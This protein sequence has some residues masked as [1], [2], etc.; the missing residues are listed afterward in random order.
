MIFIKLAIR[1]GELMLERRKNK[2]KEAQFTK[3]II[4]ENDDGT[5]RYL[6]GDVVQ[7]WEDIMN[8]LVTLGFVHG[9]QGQAGLKSIE[10]KTAQSLRELEE[11]AP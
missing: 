9:E 1:I 3:R 5:V 7:K 10:W 8:G 4:F 2:E 11:K 6:E